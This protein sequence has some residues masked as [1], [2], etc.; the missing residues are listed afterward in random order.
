V[1]LSACVLHIS[2]LGVTILLLALMSDK[3]SCA[4]AAVAAAA[5]VTTCALA[6][7]LAGEAMAFITSSTDDAA[8]NGACAL[9][10]WSNLLYPSC[11]YL[12]LLLR[13][14]CRSEQERFR[15]RDLLH[16]LKHRR[17]QIQQ[18]IKRN[19]QSS[20]RWVQLGG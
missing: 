16:A 8:I 19:Q 17:E 7:E 15:R 3:C 4:A 20:D 2:S 12:C 13:I 5:V 6:F 9:A 1:L 11:L 14:T 10:A 18:S